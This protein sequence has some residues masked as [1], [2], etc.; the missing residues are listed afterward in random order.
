[1]VSVVLLPMQN[2]GV[3]L[4][5]AKTIGGVLIKT[6]MVSC[7][8]HVVTVSTAVVEGPCHLIFTEL[9]PWPFIIVPL[10]EGEMDHWKPPGGVGPLAI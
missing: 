3:W 6:C 2:M 10:I 4:G 9:V 5:L 7:P 8:L 1:M